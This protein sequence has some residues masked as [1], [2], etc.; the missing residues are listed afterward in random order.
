MLRHRSLRKGKRERFYA[1]NGPNTTQKQLR[2][3]VTS[4]GR[5][6]F[7]AMFTAEA[8]SRFRERNRTSDE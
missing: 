2:G 4:R 5:T 6:P 7:A 8:R 3:Q 1:K